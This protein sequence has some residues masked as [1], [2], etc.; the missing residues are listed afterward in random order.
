[1][2]VC[3]EFVLYLGVVMPMHCANETDP[4]FADGQNKYLFLELVQLIMMVRLSSNSYYNCQT[5]I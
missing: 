3:E 5:K 4:E 2:D 1:M